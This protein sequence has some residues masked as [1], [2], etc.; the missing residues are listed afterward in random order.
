MAN[1][2]F[3]SQNERLIFILPYRSIIRTVG[4]HRK[5]QQRKKNKTHNN[6]LPQAS[7]PKENI[8]LEITEK[9]H[10]NLNRLVKNQGIT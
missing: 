8:H 1:Y 5:K 7:F 6:F 9:I 10:E 2:I 4:I 3:F